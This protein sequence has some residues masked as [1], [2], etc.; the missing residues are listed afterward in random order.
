MRAVDGRRLPPLGPRGE[1][2]VAIQAVILLAIA[3]G[4]LVGPAWD[5]PARSVTSLAGLALLIT[6]AGL[7]FRGMLDLGRGIT[8]LPR[9]TAGTVLIAHGA[10][11]LV[12]HPIYGGLIVVAAGWALVT[13]SLVAL[14]GSA[15]LFVFF[16]LKARREEAW[17]V[18]TVEGYAAYREG[19]HR[20]L[21]WLY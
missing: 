18:E 12:R 2:W 15:I 6:G 5:G 19:R 16:D 10:Y 8:P 20:L 3:A 9:P 14:A 17:L 11:A 13:A 1:G 21:P 7:A 4:A